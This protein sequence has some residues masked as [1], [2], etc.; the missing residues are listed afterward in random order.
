MS[1]WWFFNPVCVARWRLRS[2]D[3]K[4]A[5]LHIGQIWSRTPVWIFLW[6]WK[7]PKA[8]NCFE[9]TSHCRGFSPVCV[10]KLTN[11]CL[12]ILLNFEGFPF[13][14]NITWYES[15]GYAFAQIAWY[16]CYTGTCNWITRKI[17][18]SCNESYWEE[19]KM[20]YSRL[21]SSMSSNMDC[22]LC[23]T[24]ECFMAF[25]AR[26]WYFGLRFGATFLSLFG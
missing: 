20:K 3:V 11:R 9:H 19:N 13:R 6:A 25:V 24:L 23:S 22:Q 2:P 15:L 14:R 17:K 1:Q 16:T 21:L 26:L 8:A 12:F 18:M 7:L 4:N 10:L 5:L